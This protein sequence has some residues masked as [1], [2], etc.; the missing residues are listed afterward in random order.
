MDKTGIRKEI[1]LIR[2]QQRKEFTFLT[3]RH[4]DLSQKLDQISQKFEQTSAAFEL[5]GAAFRAYAASTDKIFD[6]LE[7][8]LFDETQPRL[9]ALESEHEHFRNRL[10]A[11]EAKV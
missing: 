2:K 1:R 4:D 7:S 8:A 5:S 9:A 3:L 11:L 6:R 10:Q